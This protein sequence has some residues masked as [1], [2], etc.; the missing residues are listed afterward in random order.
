MAVAG[1]VLFVYWWWLVFRRV[2]DTEVR[3]T[4][5]FI[6]IA[7]VVIVVVTAIWAIH[8]LRIFKHR[9]PRTKVRPVREDFSRDSVGR[10]VNM[11]KVPN[12]CVTAPVVVVRI[13][14]G[15]KIYETLDPTETAPAASRVRVG[16]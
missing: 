7:L 3:Y 6:A 16:R 11:P 8:N 4:L 9:G 10:P 15:T 5:W 14:D 2:N 12:E 13:A 1:W